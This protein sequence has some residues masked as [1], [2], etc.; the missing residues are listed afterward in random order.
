MVKR[1]RWAQVALLAWCMSIGLACQ[2]GRSQTTPT[3]TPA[4]TDATSASICESMLPELFMWLQSLQADG[5][6]TPVVEQIPGLVE[7]PGAASLPTGTYVTLTAH[8]V[9]IDGERVTTMKRFR[10]QQIRTRL[11]ALRAAAAE[12]AG[13]APTLI[14]LIQPD[15][16]W[17]DISWVAQI[18][19]RAGY[20]RLWFGFRR[21]GRVSTPSSTLLDAELETARTAAPAEWPRQAIVERWID[22]AASG[23]AEVKALFQSLA[24]E[25]RAPTE[26]EFQE[27]SVRLPGALDRCDC[28]VDLWGLQA[29]LS[30]LSGRLS[31]QV[32]GGIELRLAKGGGG[33]QLLAPG[34]Y[35]TWGEGY[36][37]LTEYARFGASTPMTIDIELSPEDRHARDQARDRLESAYDKLDALRSVKTDSDLRDDD[38]G[39]SIDHDSDNVLGDH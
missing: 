19:E 24:T 16:H 7:L 31:D 18:A 9:A 21:L 23:C 15:V 17:S 14:L 29:T 22:K 13:G 20:E 39:S 33:T 12:N 36:K 35:T 2:R 34:P 30:A 10:A 11:R 4:T 32:L 37:I 8:A 28:D 3:P 26:K 27:L 1:C 6:A 25:R 5:F 38:E